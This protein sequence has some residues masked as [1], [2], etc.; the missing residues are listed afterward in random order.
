M[1]IKSR[2]FNFAAGPAALPQ[3]VVDQVSR[4]VVD[5]KGQG[6][7]LLEQGHRTPVFSDIRDEFK[8]SMKSLL[9]LDEGHEIVCLQGGARQQFAMTLLNFC[10]GGLTPAYI[11]TG[12]W[13]YRAT[14][15]ADVGGYQPKVYWA[16]RDNGYRK[17]PSQPV[18][19]SKKHAFVH[20]TGN[21]TI[22]GVQIPEDPS[23]IVKTDNPIIMDTSSDLLSRPLPCK[24]YAMI[25]AC[26][27]KN[28]GV[29]GNTVVIIRR[30]LL[31]NSREDLPPVFAYKNLVKLDSIYNT[32]P[33]LPIYVSLLMC[34]WIK[35]E[36]GSLEGVAKFNERKAS[37]IYGLLDKYPDFYTGHSEVSARSTMNIILKFK[38]PELQDKFLEQATQK[39]FLNLKGHREL[40]GIRISNYNAITLE[41]IESLKEFMDAFVH[42]AVG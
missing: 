18:E 40:G 5:F 36:F 23:L 8:S 20:V 37:M 2:P 27:Q 6:I 41:A 32:A 34:R 3:E 28:L 1:S 31:A 26:A 9:G 33:V 22:H 13:G 10:H 14:V 4:D 12:H 42:S 21:E 15:E 19:I 29:V 11:N 24:K 25:Y 35:K 30:D 7:S 39:G 38:K 17:I 16:D